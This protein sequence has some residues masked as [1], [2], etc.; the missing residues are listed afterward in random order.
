[1][2]NYKN[3]LPGEWETGSDGQRF[4]RVGNIIEYEPRI[5]TTVGTLTPR[6]LADIND[7]AKDKP[8][9][10]PVQTAPSK[11]CPFKDGMHTDCDKAVCA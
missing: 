5:T 3:L 11:D 4:R 6:Q 7:R 1:M 9:F 2:H 10:V 8:S